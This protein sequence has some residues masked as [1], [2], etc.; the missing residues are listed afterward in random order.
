[1]HRS[2]RP[3][4]M[5]MVLILLVCFVLSLTGCLAADVRDVKSTVSEPATLIAAP[6]RNRRARSPPAPVTTPTAGKRI[7]NTPGDFDF[8]VMSLSWSPDYCAGNDDPQQCSVG[9]KLGFVLHGLWPQYNRGYPADCSNVKLSKDVQA[10]FPNLYRQRELVHARMGEAWL[11]LW[12][13]TK[14]L[15]DTG[16][17]AERIESQSRRLIAIPPSVSHH[18]R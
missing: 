15:H 5:F 16:E 3:R 14:R 4:P 9:K 7:K 18:R 8:Y 1:M 12:P 10:K 17:N 6:P 11:M 2:L 13:H